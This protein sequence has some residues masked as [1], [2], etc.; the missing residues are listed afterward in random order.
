M[1]SAERTNEI[2]GEACNVLNNS[3]RALETEDAHPHVFL[4]S[5]LKDIVTDHAGVQIVELP[6]IHIREN[7]SPTIWVGGEIAGM[8]E[9][10]KGK[11]TIA[12][13]HPLTSQR[14]TI[15][16]ELGHWY[17]HKG[18]LFFRERPMF[19]TAFA[20]TKKPLMEREADT[21]AAELLMP[22]KIVIANFRE[23]FGDEISLSEIKAEELFYISPALFPPQKFLELRRSGLRNLSLAAS[24]ANIFGGAATR[25]M[26]LHERFGVSSEAMA[27]R[28]EELSLLRE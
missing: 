16:H 4:R 24:R 15:A 17:L 22:H 14:F 6:E 27:I 11:M 8:L 18:T 1:L 20:V 2:R 10:D 9:R 13:K 3:Y 26:P 28:L 25:V 23:L 21:F 12:T 19:D 7:A 5:R